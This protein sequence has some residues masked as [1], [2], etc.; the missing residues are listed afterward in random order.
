MCCQKAVIKKKNAQMPKKMQQ[1]SAEP[2]TQALEKYDLEK[3]AAALVKELDEKYRPICRCI[4][5]RNFSSSVTHE[6]KHFIYFYLVQVAIR[7]V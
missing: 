4:V 3:A 1:D 2:T 7:S 6:T 5:G